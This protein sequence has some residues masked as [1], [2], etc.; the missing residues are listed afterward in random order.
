MFINF[1]LRFLSTLKDFFQGLSVSSH[2]VL[3]FEHSK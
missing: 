1:V 3:N 2:S